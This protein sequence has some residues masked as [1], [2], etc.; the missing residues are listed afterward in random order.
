MKRSLDL[1]LR[2]DLLALR[3]LPGTTG[4]MVV[5]FTG[6]K[7]GVGG[8]HPTEFAGSASQDGDAVLFVTDRTSSWY[9]APGLWRRVVTWVR[10]VRRSERIREV[11]SLGTSMGGY[12]AI[13]LAK[14]L[15]VT[16][17][18]AFSPQVTRDDA[19]L[20]DA[21]WRAL[22]HPLPERDLAAA[23][24]D[25]TEYLL[26]ASEGCTLDRRHIARM[27][28]T[29]NVHRLLLPGH[30]HNAAGRL[31][32]AGLLAPVVAACLSGARA[33]ARRLIDTG[34]RPEAEALS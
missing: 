28:R 17:V 14:H 15:P 10:Y 1:I 11:L 34:L 3:W 27:P 32:A 12:G 23:C 4:R 13:L 25:R 18:V 9:S 24:V 21:R 22:E 29:P 8:G 33:E 20:E 31:K 16:R 30:H 7:L 19:V 5:V 2:D 6:L 26:L